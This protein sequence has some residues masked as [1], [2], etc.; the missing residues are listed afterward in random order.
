MTRETETPCPPVR[1]TGRIETFIGTS[2]LGVFGAGYLGRTMARGL[3]AAGLPREKLTLCHR[4]SAETA[5]EI[6]SAGLTDRVAPAADVAGG[7]KILLC[8]VRP[9]DCAALADYTLLP[10]AILVSFMAGVFLDRIPVQPALVR[11]VRIMTSAPDTIA[12]KNGIAAVYPAD[13][14]IAREIVAALGLSVFPLRSETDIHAFTALGPC[15]PIALAYWESLGKVCD[16]D[17]LMETAARYGLPS[18]RQILEWADAV[19][20]RNLSASER[21]R[22]LAQAATPG[23]VTEAIVKAIAEGLPLPDALVRGI[24]R[25][26]ELARL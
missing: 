8:T 22:Y 6:A 19:R 20:P 18:Y 2:S 13:D 10:D 9:Q 24:E 16:E 11:R 7:S 21:D 15:L 5:R 3:I 1:N 14:D 17:G 26:V 23:G 25:S 12:K 4:G